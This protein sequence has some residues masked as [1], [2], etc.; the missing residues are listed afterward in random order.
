GQTGF[1]AAES[2]VSQQP[3]SKSAVLMQAM[4]TPPRDGQLHRE[5]ARLVDVV[6]SGS[7][8]NEQTQRIEAYWDLCSSVADYYLSVREQDELRGLAAGAARQSASLQE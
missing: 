5:S 2:A 1:S 7:T 4:L 3:P 8:R 6:R